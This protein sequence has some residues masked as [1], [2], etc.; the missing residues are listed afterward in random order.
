[1]IAAR[2]SSR[3]DSPEIGLFPSLPLAQNAADRMIPNLQRSREG[4]RRR[5]ARGRRGAAGMSVGAWLLLLALLV[6]PLWACWQLAITIS[7]RVLLGYVAAASGITFLIYRHDK[8][9]AESGGWR[10]PEATLHLLELLGG[11]PGAF[12]AQRL[13]RHKTSKRS[14]QV[15]FWIIVALHQWMSFD[16]IQQWR[17]SKQALHALAGIVAVLRS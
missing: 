9:R 1:M 3:A 13:L 15:S 12:L 2:V 16:F 5:G 14:Y 11:W 7:W 8:K 10:T 6:T 17:Y 4:Q